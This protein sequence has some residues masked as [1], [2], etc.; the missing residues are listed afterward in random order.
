[1]SDNRTEIYS[2]SGR[3]GEAYVWMRDIED[4]D[5]KFDDLKALCLAKF[6]LPSLDGGVRLLYRSAT[7]QAVFLYPLQQPVATNLSKSP[8]SS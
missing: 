1:M 6:E 2:K 3:G 5:V 4:P 7:R 8:P